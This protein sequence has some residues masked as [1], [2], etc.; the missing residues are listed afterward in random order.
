MGNRR[1]LKLWG[2]SSRCIARDPQQ[3]FRRD[4][5]PEAVPLH[6]VGEVAARRQPA[7]AG[8]RHAFEQPPVLAKTVALVQLRLIGAPGPWNRL[9]RFWNH[10]P[11]PRSRRR[12][13]K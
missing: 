10:W 3:P 13:K 6:L 5:R 7:G 8:E 9:G 2:R 12:T 4:D 11:R 1:D